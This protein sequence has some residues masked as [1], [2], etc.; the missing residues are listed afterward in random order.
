[1]EVPLTVV[2]IA[3][4]LSRLA[5]GVARTLPNPLAWRTLAA[6]RYVGAVGI[7]PAWFPLE[8]MMLA[9]RLHRRRGGRVLHLSLHS[10]EL[11][12]GAT[13]SFPSEASVRRLTDKIR[14]FLSW[15]S[16]L[17]EVEGVTLSQAA[18]VGGEGPA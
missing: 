4:R 5:Y 17:T 3:L 7:Q 13:P 2:P 15:L 14:R 16:A 1:L 12:P 10:S 6:F 18:D 9:A 11:M 8:S